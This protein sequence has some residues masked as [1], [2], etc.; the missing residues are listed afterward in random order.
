MKKIIAVTLGLALVT[1]SFYSCKKGDN[2]PFLSLRTR[3][4]RVVG[5]WT[6]S[7]EEINETNINGTTTETIQ[8]IYDGTRRITTT[9]TKIGTIT[10]TVVDTMGFKTTFKLLKDGTYNMTFVDDNHLDV[11]TSI[12]TWLFL[13]KS[14]LDKLKKKEAILLTTTQSIISNG[15]VTNTVN[16]TD[17]NGLTIVIDELKNKEM[18]T[19]VQEDSEN[20]TGL[21]S[22]KKTTKTT[23]IQN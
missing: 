4:A 15:S 11:V 12:G 13:G 14:K 9:T 23:Y 7:K 22:N 19:I 17:L 8:S 18:I 2:D 6:V 1:G 16:Y 3:K 5:S 10:T 21:V 20:S